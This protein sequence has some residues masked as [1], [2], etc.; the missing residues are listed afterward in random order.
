MT[1]LLIV[2]LVVTVVLALGF[3]FRSMEVRGLRADFRREEEAKRNPPPPSPRKGIITAQFVGAGLINKG[4]QYNI[5]ADVIEEA[6]AGDNSLIKVTKVYG[7]GMGDYHQK[8]IAEQLSGWRRTDSIIW[9]T[10]P[11]PI[12]PAEPTYG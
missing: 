4:A 11:E 12:K 10:P 7:A 8:D 2:W 3:I 5:T 1:A 9:R 6:V